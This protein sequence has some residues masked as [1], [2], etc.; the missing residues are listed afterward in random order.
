MYE[1]IGRLYMAYREAFEKVEWLDMSWTEDEE[2]MTA[3][4]KAERKLNDYIKE[5]EFIL[6]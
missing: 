4:Y 6:K 1:Q 3:F 2:I 5:I